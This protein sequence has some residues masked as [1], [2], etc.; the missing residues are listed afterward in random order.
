M[1]ALPS[2]GADHQHHRACKDQEEVAAKRRA[3]APRWSCG[4]RRRRRSICAC[5]RHS[6][7]SWHNRGNRRNCRR[8]RWRF[9]RS[10]CC[11][12]SGEIGLRHLQNRVQK[13]TASRR[14]AADH[15]I[16]PHLLSGSPGA[17]VKGTSRHAVANIPLFGF[18]TAPTIACS[19][20]HLYTDLQRERSAST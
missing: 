15:T 3:I 12:L 19:A 13:V 11:S 17:H 7:H 10:P 4:R 14:Q 6:W 2:Q 16:L 20:F 18:L 8:W 5:N 9:S 1:P